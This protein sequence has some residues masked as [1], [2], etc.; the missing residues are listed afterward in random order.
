MVFVCVNS[1]RVF[2]HSS[3]LSVNALYTLGSL[4]YL[5]FSLSV[6]SKILS[7]AGIY[8]DNFFS[9]TMCIAAL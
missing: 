8:G 6:T 7:S 5:L 4:R 3:G 1:H 2:S 9:V